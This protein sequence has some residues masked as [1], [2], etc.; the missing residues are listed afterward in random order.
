MI[1]AAVLAAA[2]GLAGAAA[3]AGA[4]V[5][6]IVSPSGNIHCVYAARTDPR[7]QGGLFCT[8][9]RAVYA[10]A[11]QSRCVNGPAAVDWHGWSLT[12]RGKG[13]VVC[14]GGVL[15]FG[16]P[17]YVRLAYGRDWHAGPYTCHS[18]VTGVTCRNRARH[19]LFISRASWRVW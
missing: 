16:R 7:N 18:A 13:S 19:G 11:L 17:R 2:V 3:A 9:G 10:R 4:V 6:G 1:R 14:T 5:P 8:I 15:W 12:V